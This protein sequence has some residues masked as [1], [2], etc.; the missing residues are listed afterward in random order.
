LQRKTQRRSWID[1]QLDNAAKGI[2][3]FFDHVERHSAQDGT[4][5]ARRINRC[6]EAIVGI[7]FLLS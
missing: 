1:G 7:R 4:H 2:V 5:F 3:G 6:Y